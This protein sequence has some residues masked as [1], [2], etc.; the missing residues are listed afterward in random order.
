MVN[1]MDPTE[2][3]HFS[4]QTTVQQKALNGMINDVTT[5]IGS[6]TGAGVFEGAAAEN[7]IGLWNKNKPVMEQ[8]AVD[9]GK[10]STY[11]REQAQLAR[12]LNKPFGQV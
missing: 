12:D 7:L 2:L 3:D 8:L 10:W 1:R 6:N 9:L 5:A 4:D 11:C